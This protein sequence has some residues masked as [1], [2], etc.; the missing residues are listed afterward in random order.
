MR[1]ALIESTHLKS[2]RDLIHV[3]DSLIFT[4]KFIRMDDLVLNIFF[5][6]EIALLERFKVVEEGVQ[7]SERLVTLNFFSGCGENLALF[8]FFLLLLN[9]ISFGFD[10]WSIL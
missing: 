1:E 2:H 6:L 8:K 10:T 7:V 4:V 3:L 9:I 5:K